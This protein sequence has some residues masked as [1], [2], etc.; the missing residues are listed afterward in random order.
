LRNSSNAGKPNRSA[1]RA[2]LDTTIIIDAINDRNRR[3]Q[4]LERLL[5]EGALLACCPINVTEGFMECAP[6]KTEAFLASLEF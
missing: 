2:L 3:S 6:A 4:L 5:A 1:P